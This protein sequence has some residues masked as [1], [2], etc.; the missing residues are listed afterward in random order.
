[1][2]PFF[3]PWLGYY[4]LIDSVDCFILLD[5]VELSKQSWQTRNVFITH[6]S[7]IGNQSQ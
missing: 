4:E 1:M 7:V 5:D 2:Q 3:I 6:L